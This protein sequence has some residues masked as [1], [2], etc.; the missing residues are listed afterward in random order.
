MYA[1]R[2]CFTYAK[3]V[4]SCVCLRGTDIDRIE[5]EREREKE[6]EKENQMN[7]KEIS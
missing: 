1:F 2:V 5:R 3:R 4:V 7:E 6:K